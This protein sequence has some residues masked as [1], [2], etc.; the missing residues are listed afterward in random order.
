MRLT[1]CSHRAGLPL[2]MNL[3]STEMDPSSLSYEELGWGQVDVSNFRPSLSKR[4][5]DK[6][7]TI[8]GRDKS[9]AESVGKRR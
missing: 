9:M 6:I 7:E 2:P 5:I 4:V 1:S 3:V 8:V